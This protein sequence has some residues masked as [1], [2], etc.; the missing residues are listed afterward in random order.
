MP[1]RIDAILGRYGAAGKRAKRACDSESNPQGIGQGELGERARHGDDFPVARPFARRSVATASCALGGVAL[2]ALAFYAAIAARE[3][4]VAALAGA[5]GL[6]LLRWARAERPYSAA[7]IA[8]DAAAFAIFAFQRNDSLGFWQ[9]PGPWADVWRFN[10]PGATIALIVYVGG[11]IMAL[12]GGLSRASA[13]RGAGPDCGPLS[14]Q[15]PL[16]RRRRL[17]HGRDRG[18]GDRARKPAVCRS[19]RDRARADPVVRRRGDADADQPGQRQSAPAIGADARAVCALSGAIAAA[20]A[21]HRQ[22]RA[23]GRPAVPRDLRLQRLRRAGS[24]GP[25]GDRLSPDR[26]LPR[27]A[28]RPPAAF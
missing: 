28:W 12:V 16:G 3:P 17:A 4:I 15:P 13:H 19:G 5:A 6:A 10:P 9:L 8:I 20:D 11:A 7:L 18:R 22:R 27:L 21:A 25:V 24:S 1:W 26:H 2:L 14:V 23:M